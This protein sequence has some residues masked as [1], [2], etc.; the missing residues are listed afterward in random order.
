[1]YRFHPA[2]PEK[3]MVHE[4]GDDRFR[5][6][7]Q[8]DGDNLLVTTIRVEEGNMVSQFTVSVEALKTLAE[9]VGSLNGPD[10]V[11]PDLVIA[12]HSVLV[13]YPPGKPFP[14]AVIRFSDERWV[15]PGQGHKGYL[16]QAAEVSLWPL[17]EDMTEVARR[18]ERAH[19]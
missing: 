12:G 11:K 7:V 19:G 14:M 17:G 13:L 1:M 18:M 5:L 8:H 10:V 4:Y 16:L 15:V 3:C 6:L 2:E 9:S